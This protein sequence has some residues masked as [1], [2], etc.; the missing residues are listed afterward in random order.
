MIK[1]FNVIIFVGLFVPLSTSASV[2]D[3]YT[4]IS[5]QYVEVTKEKGAKNFRSV[6]FEFSWA[7]P[8]DHPEQ[9]IWIPSHPEL[10]MSETI[11]LIEEQPYPPVGGTFIR[12]N[13]HPNSNSN[14]T[15]TGGLFYEGQSESSLYLTMSSS[16][17]QSITSV[18]ASCK[19][20]LM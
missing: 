12:F 5:S 13:L 16:G 15:N 10:M 1:L 7:S 2:G 17:L 4:C 20:N 11:Y 8:K 6:K 18:I 19:K 14:I 9:I 3:K